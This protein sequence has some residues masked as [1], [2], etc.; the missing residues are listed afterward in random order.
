MKVVWLGIFGLVP[1]F[2]APC[3]SV[4]LTTPETKARFQELDR[5]AQ[6]EFRHAEFAKA[7]EDFRQATCVAP[8]SIRSYYELYGNATSAVAEADFV[9]ARRILE[10]ADKLRPD[11]PLPLAMQVQVSLLAGDVAELKASLLTAAQRFPREGRLHA[12][13]AQDL[14]HHKQYDL[15]L[16]E[17]LRAE[18][19]GAGSARAGLNLA[20]LESQVGAFDDAAKLATAIE[21]QAGLSEKERASAAGIAGLSLESLGQLAEAVRQFKLAVRLD[22][23]QEQPYL[24]LARIY[25]GQQDNH[26]A[27]EILTQARK[28][29][30]DSPNVLLAL[31]SA[32]VSTE[33]YQ[34]ASEMLAGLIQSTPDQLE[35]YPKLAEAYR[36][37]GEP[38][39]ATETLRQLARRKP[40]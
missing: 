12:E 25:A 11:Y 4:T 5:R 28:T 14:V 24:A 39:R 6:V 10:E 35:A 7:V 36:N 3:P 31:G 1:V 9:R 33:Q 26:G 8:E 15:A 16:A 29:L 17:A 21:Q 27:V 37:M 32:L 40:G 22:A 30:G 19:S 38:R 20:V 34:A 2:A 13:L 18:E 23:K